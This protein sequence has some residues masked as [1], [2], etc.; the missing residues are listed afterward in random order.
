MIFPHEVLLSDC[1]AAELRK[2]SPCFSYSEEWGDQHS[3][4][5]EPLPLSVS[6]SILLPQVFVESEPSFYLPVE[7]TREMLLLLGHILLC[8]FS[9]EFP[10]RQR[11]HMLMG[12][13]MMFERVLG[14]IMIFP[15]KNIK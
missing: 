1:V 9:S 8:S 3:V 11:K 5:D 12:T 10:N 7:S 15:K 13:K 2:S 6:T 14:L 4:P